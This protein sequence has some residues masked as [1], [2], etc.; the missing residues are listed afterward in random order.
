MGTSR[1]GEEEIESSKERRTAAHVSKA[2]MQREGLQGQLPR[3]LV[4]DEVDGLMIH[5]GCRDLFNVKTSN[6]LLKRELG[7]KSLVQSLTVNS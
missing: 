6:D 5:P 4:Q 2:C 3:S 1:Q 7:M